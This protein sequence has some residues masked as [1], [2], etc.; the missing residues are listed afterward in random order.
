MSI[1]R[2]NVCENTVGDRPVDCERRVHYTCAGPKMSSE[3]AYRARIAELE[4]TV[5]ALQSTA[6]LQ[7]TRKESQFHCQYCGQVV[8][9]GACGC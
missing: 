6:A 4:K 1:M 8:K 7:T 2:C 5:A 3:N 9:G